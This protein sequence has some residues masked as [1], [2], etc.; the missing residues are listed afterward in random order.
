MAKLSLNDSKG[1][2]GERVLPR[3]GSGC[4]EIVPK[5]KC[6]LPLGGGVTNEDLWP[7][8]MKGRD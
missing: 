7:V 1:F 2:R 4:F 3:V 6:Q 8:W 5:T